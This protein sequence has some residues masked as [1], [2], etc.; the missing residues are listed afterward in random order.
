VNLYVT[1]PALINNPFLSIFITYET[2]KLLILSFLFFL[3]FKEFSKYNLEAQRACFSSP[4]AF[5]LK[6]TL[7]YEKGGTK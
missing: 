5:N 1:N 3:L 7:I 4:G 6:L 2:Q